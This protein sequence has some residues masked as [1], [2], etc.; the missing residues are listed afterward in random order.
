MRFFA[1]DGPFQKYGTILFDLI[2][3]LY[4]KKFVLEPA[5]IDNLERN[6]LCTALFDQYDQLI[7]FLQVLFFYKV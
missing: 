3:I 4:G 2:K 1:L 7:R 6:A 5:V